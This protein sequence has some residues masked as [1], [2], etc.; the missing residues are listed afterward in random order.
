MVRSLAYRTFQ[1][2]YLLQE[3]SLGDPEGRVQFDWTNGCVGRKKT[4]GC[5]KS[6]RAAAAERSCVR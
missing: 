1:L 4:P 2:R 5:T 6:R 3:H